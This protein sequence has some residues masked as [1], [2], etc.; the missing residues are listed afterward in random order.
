[1]YGLSVAHVNDLIDSSKVLEVTS[2]LLLLYGIGSTVGPTLAGGVMDLFGPEAL[3]LYFAIVLGLMAVSVWVFAPAKFIHAAA[4]SHKTD[5]VV[6][7][8][9]SQAVLQMDP[10]RPDFE[11]S[12]PARPFTDPGR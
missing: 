7:G 5:Y 1:V 12:R 3:M 8:S 4:G 2:G 11:H 10:R 9:G 6:M